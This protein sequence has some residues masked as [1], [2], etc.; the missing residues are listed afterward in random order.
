MDGNGTPYL[1]EFK[2]KLSSLDDFESS[3]QTNVYTLRS[4]EE[5]EF[6]VRKNSALT[7]GETYCYPY[8]NTFSNSNIFTEVGNDDDINYF[9]SFND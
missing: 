7:S 4:V 3:L 6:F 1:Y 9:Q 5:D 8:D 2:F